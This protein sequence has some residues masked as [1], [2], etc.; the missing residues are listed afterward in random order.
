MTHVYKHY[1]AVIAVETIL[2][3]MQENLA[4]HRWWKLGKSLE[5]YMLWLY[6]LLNILG[7]DLKG[8]L[9]QVCCDECQIWVHVECDLTCNNVE[10]ISLPLF[11]D[12]LM[13]LLL[14]IY[15]KLFYE[16]L[17]LTWHSVIGFG[18]GRLLL[19]G[20]QIKT[21]NSSSNG[22]NEYFHQFRVSRL[23]LSNLWIQN[24]LS[25]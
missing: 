20:L 12:I 9:C 16:Y 5:E 17:L 7:T 24:Y 1:S 19:S 15:M 18:K 4:P 11:D 23:L 14:D 6:I 13:S 25:K 3:H 10:V 8:T 22:K 2:W 21:Q